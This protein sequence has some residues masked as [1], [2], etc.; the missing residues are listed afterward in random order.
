MSD[1]EMENQYKDKSNAEVEN[2][3]LGCRLRGEEKERY[4]SKSWKP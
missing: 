2:Q 1:A 4:L 3:C